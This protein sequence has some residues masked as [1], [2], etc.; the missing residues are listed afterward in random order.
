ML[1]CHI[2]PSNKLWKALLIFR[3]LWNLEL[4]AGASLR[5]IPFLLLWSH[6]HLVP[7]EDWPFRKVAGFLGHIWGGRDGAAKLGIST[8]GVWAIRPRLS[9]R[10]SRLAGKE[11]MRTLDFFSLS[12]SSFWH[13][14][15]PLEGL[16]PFNGDFSY[17][18]LSSSASL[19][20]RVKYL[21]LGSTI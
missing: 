9:I 7:C 15:S 17:V 14:L 5:A 18:M 8:K 21:R 1:V 6:C 20:L 3:T 11:T 19:W 16:S 10:G 12:V 2:L 4:T 13:L